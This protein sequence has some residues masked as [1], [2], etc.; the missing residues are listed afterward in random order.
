MSTGLRRIY[1]FDGKWR[2]V[3]HAIRLLRIFLVGGEHA[4]ASGFGTAD[5][6]F[7][8]RKPLQIASRMAH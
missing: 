2:L 4:K 5:A 6:P 8:F 1:F 7:A 3:V